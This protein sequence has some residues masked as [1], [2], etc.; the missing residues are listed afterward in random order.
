MLCGS[1]AA[2]IKCF[3]V[4]PQPSPVMDMLYS[5]KRSKEVFSSY[6][7]EKK[8]WSI[9]E[10][11][12]M[13]VKSDQITTALHLSFSF[14]DLLYSSAM[15]INLKVIII[16]YHNYIWTQSFTFSGLLNQDNGKG[17]PNQ[18]HPVLTVCDPVRFWSQRETIAIMHLYPQT[19]NLISY[20]FSC[21][22][23]MLEKNIF[24]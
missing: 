22:E 15:E 23:E 14:Y 12:I 1:W 11:S 17:W 24:T 3:W 10:D 4:I 5:Q 13:A 9:P 18:N 16:F 2:P 7:S 19:L 8:V 20:I 6:A 21:G